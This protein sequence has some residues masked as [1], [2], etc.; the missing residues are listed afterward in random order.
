MRNLEE[1]LQDWLLFSIAN[2]F[3]IPLAIRRI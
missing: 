1:A 2:G 3:P